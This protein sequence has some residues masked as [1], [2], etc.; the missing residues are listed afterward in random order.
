MKKDPDERYQ[1]VEQFHDEL[2]KMLVRPR[3]CKGPGG[4]VVQ[5]GAR[6][7]GPARSRWRAAFGRY[8]LDEALGAGGMG[9]VYRAWAPDLR[10]AVALKRI[11]GEG[12]PELAARFL[13]E[14]R[15]AARLRHPAIVRIHDVGQI[16]NELYL[17]MDLIEG[18]TLDMVLRR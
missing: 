15:L 16:D 4:M 1:R 14:A 18:P 9:V 12:Q 3:R 8:R 11:R 2:E 17:T 7:D 10:R 5:D 6:P 13:R